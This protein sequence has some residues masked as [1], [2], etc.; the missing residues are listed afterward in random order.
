MTFLLGGVYIALRDV[1]RTLCIFFSLS[2]YISLLYTGLVN[3][4]LHTLYFIF[5]YDDDVCFF[6]T[7]LYMCFFFSI[8]IHMFLYVRNS[9]FCFTDDALRSFV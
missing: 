1:V 8:F 3:I 2:F 9:Y 5:I 4:L 6:L 7:Y